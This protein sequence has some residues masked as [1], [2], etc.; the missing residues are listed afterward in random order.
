M[1][2]ETALVSDTFFFHY[3]HKIKGFLCLRI[4][5]EKCNICGQKNPNY[6]Q[7]KLI[8]LVTDYDNIPIMAFTDAEKSYDFIS[9][10][11]LANYILHDTGLVE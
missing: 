9:Q 3:C 4:Y 8:F 1:K 5:H 6:I 11:P 7:N 10:N 2:A